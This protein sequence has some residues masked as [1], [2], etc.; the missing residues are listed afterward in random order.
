M[1]SHAFTRLNSNAHPTATV[2]RDGQN[3]D[4]RAPFHILE[5]LDIEIKVGEYV[6]YSAMTKGGK[7]ESAT[8]T[9]S[10]LTGTGDEPFLASKAVVK[11]AADIAGLG[12]ASAI[13]I[14]AIKLS[15][16]KNSL[17][18]FTLGSTTLSAN[19]N[20]QLQVNGDME[21]VYDSNTYRDLDTANTKKALQIVITGSTLIGATQYN[22]MTIQLA[23]VTL[24]SWDRSDG[25]D[26][27][28]TQTFGFNA[29]YAVANTQTLNIVLQNTKSSAY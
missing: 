4:E 1:Y 9:A 3:A 25:V 8:Y 5:T 22:S 29:E 11:I 21:I 10:Y 12:A 24:E 19:V 2:Y 28:I 18:V 13:D 15:L 20:Q 26:N 17:G 7:I 27:L 14:Q 16:K 6:K 23:Q